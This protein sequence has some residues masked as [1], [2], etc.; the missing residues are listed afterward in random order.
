MEVIQPQRFQSCSHQMR[1]EYSL[2][3]Q[4]SSLNMHHGIVDNMDSQ[5]CCSLMRCT[6]IS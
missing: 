6:D 3:P 2:V 5:T 4:Q 1:C